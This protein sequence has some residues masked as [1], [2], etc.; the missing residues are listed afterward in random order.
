MKKKIIIAL[1]T[2]LIIIA[3]FIIYDLIDDK[4]LINNSSQD[5]SKTIMCCE[6]CLNYGT[7]ED[8]KNCLEIIKQN[9]GLRHCSL[10]FAENTPTFSQCKRI[11]NESK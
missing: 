3:S 4:R 11:I 8:D 9:G 6:N 2:V 7:Y 1:I 5:S 10:V